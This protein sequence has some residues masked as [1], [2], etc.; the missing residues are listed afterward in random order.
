MTDKFYNITIGSLKTSADEHG[1]INATKICN[2]FN[3]EFRQWRRQ[4][5]AKAILNS[6]AK[7]EKTSSKS[8][9]RTFENGK[10]K[11]RGTYVHP[12]LVVAII[13]WCSQN[14]IVSMGNDLVINYGIKYTLPEP[15][16]HEK[17]DSDSGI[18]LLELGS[19]EKCRPHLN[20]SSR[21]NDKHLVCKYGISYNI[22]RRMTDHA[23]T[24]TFADV[25]PK[26]IYSK[27]IDCRYNYNAEANLTKMFKAL[28][29]KVRHERYK[30]L[31]IFPEF[32]LE[33]IQTV[34]DGICYRYQTKL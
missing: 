10:I 14:N 32:L 15:I 8:L 28:K 1:Y 25:T 13:S 11:W 2:L 31:I 34:Y 4:A 9:L 18:Y 6:L 26:L 7:E 16:N 3:K 5:Q 12:K 20:L 30:E 24:Y 21:C 33:I 22:P 23:K 27:Y 19:V 17:I 29:I